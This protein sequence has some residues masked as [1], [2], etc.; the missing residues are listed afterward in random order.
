MIR[1]EQGLLKRY[2]HL[3]TGN[4]HPRTALTYED[5]GCFTA[6]PQVCQDVQEVFRRLTGLGVAGRLHRLLQAPFDLHPALVQAIEREAAA[7]LAGRKALIRVKVNAL[8]EPKI[9]QALCMASQAGVGIELIVRGV[10][11][12]RP[13]VPGQSE[14][15]RVISVLGRFLEHSRVFH[16]H[17]DGDDDVWLA[18]ADWMNRNFFRRVEVAFPVRDR[19]LRQR[20]IEEAFL[21]HLAP[22]RSVWEM[23]S[24]GSYRLTH[25][26]DAP[27]T[28]SSQWALLA[29]IAGRRK[30]ADQLE[31]DVTGVAPA[32]IL[33]R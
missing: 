3:G 19:K 28:A 8:T 2:A 5:F 18:S 1:R 11:M 21:V 31:A 6:D 26:D 13:G 9:I 10:C 30:G 32:T 29:Q 20:V 7:A 17:A 15:I 14:N 22:E 23:A 25:P 16:F 33:A 24:D 4:Y 12:L 27:E